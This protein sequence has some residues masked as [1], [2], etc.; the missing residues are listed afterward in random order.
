MRGSIK[1]EDGNDPVVKVSVIS[2]YDECLKLCNQLKLA[3]GIY[4][5]CVELNK[6]LSAE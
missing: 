4:K 6:E 3:A 5:R 1:N 2:D